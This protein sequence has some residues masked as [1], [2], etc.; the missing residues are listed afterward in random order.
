MS[1]G[2]T[3]LAVTVVLVASGVSAPAQDVPPCRSRSLNI[4]HAINAPEATRAVGFV[5]VQGSPTRVHLEVHQTT[6]RSALAALRTVYNI[7]Y[8]SWTALNDTRDGTYAGSLRQVI[9][10]LLRN[11]NYVIKADDASFDVEIFD[12]VGA[13]AVPAPIATE[14]KEKPARRPIARVSRTR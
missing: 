5:C 12:T 6:I 13:Q 2:L 14:V 1:R 4:E 10:R 11:Y 3:G 7:S 9:S 8:S